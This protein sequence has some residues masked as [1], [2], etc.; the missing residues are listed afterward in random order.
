MALVR[1]KNCDKLTADE[2]KECWHCR[3]SPVAGGD[4]AN[5]FNC[6]GDCP[7]PQH[8]TKQNLCSKEKYKKLKEKS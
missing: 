5:G 3:G 7:T 6:C 1:C 4:K 2:F 8:C